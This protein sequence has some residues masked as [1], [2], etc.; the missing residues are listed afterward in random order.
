MWEMRLCHLVQAVWPRVLSQNTLLPVIKDNH[1]GQGKCLMCPWGSAN[2]TPLKSHRHNISLN[3]ST[4][5]RKH[6]PGRK[7]FLGT[8]SPLHIGSYW[9]AIA[10]KTVKSIK[11]GPHD[12]LG[13][14]VTK[15]WGQLARE[16]SAQT[17]HRHPQTLLST[18]V[19]HSHSHGG[20]KLGSQEE[21][22]YIGQ[23][24]G[25]SGCPWFWELLLKSL[26]SLIALQYLL[27]LGKT[28]VIT[29]VELPHI[30]CI[31]KST[32]GTI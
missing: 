7:H 8:H 32:W 15:A 5:Q 2:D 11:W 30:G 17:M 4:R 12:A 3:V 23:W 21:Q 13:C 26:Q 1:H 9:Q 31:L 27:K 16:F 25:V 28:E 10:S 29:T 20:W 24:G 14:Y 22:K 6:F 18:T 19:P